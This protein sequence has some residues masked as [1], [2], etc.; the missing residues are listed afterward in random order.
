MLCRS[1]IAEA[2]APASTSSRRTR[3][4]RLQGIC[5]AGLTCPP[6]AF[7]SQDTICDG[8]GSGSRLECRLRPGERGP[9]G[10]LQPLARRPTSDHSG[11]CWLTRYT[12]TAAPPPPLGHMRQGWTDPPPAR[13]L[14]GP[15][16]AERCTNRLTNRRTINPSGIYITMLQCGTVRNTTTLSA[17]GERERTAL[18]QRRYIWA[19][20][21]ISPTTAG[22]RE[23]QKSGAHNRVM[24]Y[25][26]RGHWWS[27]CLAATP[28]ANGTLLTKPPPLCG[29]T[30][31]GGSHGNRPLEPTSGAGTADC[32]ETSIV[33]TMRCA[34]NSGTLWNSQSWNSRA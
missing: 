26:D 5:G 29:I 4:A 18:T 33:E 25:P 34:R 6:P 14:R 10:V 8:S 12:P 3:S 31:V 32:T 28:F 30:A 15:Q 27:R 24:E 2:R 7:P 9:R 1:F 19:G 17:G 22:C 21:E 11:M 16:G 23:G 13:P 20:Q